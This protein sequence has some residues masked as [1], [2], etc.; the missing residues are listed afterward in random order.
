MTSYHMNPFWFSAASWKI[1]L[2]RWD[3]NQWCQVAM[4]STAIKWILYIIMRERTVYGLFYT[5]LFLY[6]ITGEKTC[7]LTTTKMI[8]L[9]KWTKTGFTCQIIRDMSISILHI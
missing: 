4:V 9:R 7:I 6:I 2:V 8:F 5:C 3:I 1:E